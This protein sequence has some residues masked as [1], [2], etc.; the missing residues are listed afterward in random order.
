[1]D[2]FANL[3]APLKWII[4]VTGLGALIGVGGMAGRG[5]WKMLLIF[6]VILIGL[7]LVV[8]GG[9]ILWNYWQRKKQNARLR[10]ELQQSTTAAPRGMSATD[11]A[12]L[13]SLRKKFQEGVDAFHGKR[14]AKFKGS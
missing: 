1:M 12:K 3:P 8:V 14:A 5:S 10:G 4:G 13:D 7:L 6:S 11:L 2:K 9:F